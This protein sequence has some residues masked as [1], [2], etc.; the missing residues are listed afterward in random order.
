[1]EYFNGM[2][3]VSLSD[4]FPMSE[5]NKKVHKHTVPKKCFATGTGKYVNC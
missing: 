3:S 2:N 4:T 1:M 5:L